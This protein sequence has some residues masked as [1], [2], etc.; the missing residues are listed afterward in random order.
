[1]RKAKSKNTVYS[2]H[3]GLNRASHQTKNTYACGTVS[4]FV[5]FIPGYLSFFFDAGAQES[6]DPVIVRRGL[7]LSIEY[8]E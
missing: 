8:I 1:M 5:G 3:Q 6:L 2:R 7:W 4:F